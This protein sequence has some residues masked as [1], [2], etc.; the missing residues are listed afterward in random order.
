MRLACRTAPVPPEPICTRPEFV[1]GFVIVNVAELAR[2][3]RPSGP[4][5]VEVPDTV[6][7]LFTSKLPKTSKVAF[8]PCEPDTCG[9]EPDIVTELGPKLVR[10]IRAPPVTW[11]PPEM[12]N[13]P[14]P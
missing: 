5:T 2:V 14:A 1:I 4:M 3:R 10:P 7:R 13:V 9:P 6:A 11:A 8:V 12:V